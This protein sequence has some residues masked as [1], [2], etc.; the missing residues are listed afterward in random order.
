MKKK[1]LTAALALLMIALAV[2]GSLAFFT[3]E[4]EA[5]NTFTLG[6]VSI[7]I[8]E[9]GE[10]T[11]SDRVIFDKPMIPVVNEQKITTDPGYV[12]KAVKVESTGENAAYIRVHL[13][14]PTALVEY[15]ELRMN[16]DDSGWDYIGTSDTKLVD[17]VAYTVKT[18]DYKEAVAPKA[19]TPELLLGAYLRSEVDTKDNPATP[20]EDLEFCKPDGDG[21]AFSG[22]VAHRKTASGYSSNT[23]CILVA[24]E[25]MQDRGFTDATTALNTG[26]GENTNPWQ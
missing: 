20:A 19:F 5:T 7:E 2:G 21:Y 22:F 17:G 1:V 4:D 6:S 18:Y 3:A 25:A 13:A 26:F 14:V 9:N 8:W 16:P 11:N 10:A 23:V 12:P 15:L 24:A